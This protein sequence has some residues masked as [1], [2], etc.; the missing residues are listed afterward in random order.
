MFIGKLYRLKK[1]KAAFGSSDSRGVQL[2]FRSTNIEIKIIQD[3]AEE[4]FV[5]V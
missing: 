2:S 5:P 3:N 1:A 4:L